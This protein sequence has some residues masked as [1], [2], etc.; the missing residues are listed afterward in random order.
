VLSLLVGASPTYPLTGASLFDWKLGAGATQ[1]VPNIRSANA[2]FSWSPDRAVLVYGD[3]DVPGGPPRFVRRDADGHT[4]VIL[5]T[6]TLRALPNGCDLSTRDLLLYGQLHWSPDGARIAVVGRL[7]PQCCYFLA[8]ART[9]GGEP[10]L[11]RSPESC[12]FNDEVEWLDADRLVA[13]LTGPECGRTTLEGRAIIIDA[14]SGRALGEVPV[15]RKSQLRLSPDRRWLASSGPGEVLTPLDAPAQRL[16]VPL[17]GSL[18]SWCC[19]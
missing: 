5:S 3:A 9:D 19:Q 1:L 10:V 18:I 13:E 11:F 7:D 2:E 6:D 8:I 14:R 12:F 4:T 16:V 15:G 17:P